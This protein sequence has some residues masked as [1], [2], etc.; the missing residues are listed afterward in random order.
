[1]ILFDLSNLIHRNLHVLEDLKDSVGNSTGGAFGCLNSI[2]K[3]LKQRKYREPCICFLDSGIPLF[4]RELYSN[5]KA[6]KMPVSQDGL[7]MS[8]YYSD[9]NKEPEDLDLDTASFLKKYG[10]NRDL[11]N[12]KILPA[13]GIPSIQIPNTEADDIISLFA[14]TV[15]DEHNTIITSDRDMLQLVDDN[16]DW[17]DP[18]R[19]HL[20]DK[21]GLIQE[22]ELNPEY[23]QKNYKLYKAINGDSSDGIPGIEGIG[24]TS[25][26]KL[27]RR[28]VEGDTI[29]SME[30]PPRCNSKGFENFKNSKDIIFRNLKLVDLDYP[31]E[32]VPEYKEALIKGLKSVATVTPDEYL[33]N[34][35]LKSYSMVTSLGLVPYIIQAQSNLDY[36]EV[37]NTYFS[38]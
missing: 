23:Y 35:I 10:F 11:L 18:I 38:K 36:F 14:K 30:R 24:G 32:E 25:A 20:V 12:L 37:I 3:A 29:E 33:A 9:I 1:M 26:K 27:A 21:N 34:D 5:Y 4:R 7:D 2:H 22:W 13:L 31:L 19:D 6:H 17:Y 15:R 16:T 28:L 8:K